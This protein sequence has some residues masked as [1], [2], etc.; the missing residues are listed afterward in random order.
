MV[1]QGDK[2]M[3]EIG[4]VVFS[5]SGWSSPV[6]QQEF[7]R[8]YQ[9]YLSERSPE[10][11]YRLHWEKFPSAQLQQS[12][13][14]F[15][16]VNEYAYYRPKGSGTILS[17][18]LPGS[19]GKPFLLAHFSPGYDR[20]EIY[21]KED[22]FYKALKEDAFPFLEVM[23]SNALSLRKGII[24]HSCGIADNGKGYLFSGKSGNGKSTMARLWGEEATVLSD[25]RVMICREGR[26][27]VIMGIP[28]NTSFTP[29]SSITCRLKKI[30]FIE[31]ASE[32]RCEPLSYQASLTQLLLRS[33]LPLWDKAA[34]NRAVDLLQSLGSRILCFR[35]GFLPDS[36][37]IKY[38][39]SREALG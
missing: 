20:C 34:L 39:R 5:V 33:S 37:V 16:S 28:R 30:F 3:V 13:S 26:H 11:H 18:K 14:V 12:D 24:M 25:E 17:V 4:R 7:V 29:V 21:S 1:K 19:T 15:R 8:T 6:L 38:V 22:N 35:L 31:H 36:S 32:F 2:V 27:F 10:V 23:L 9:N